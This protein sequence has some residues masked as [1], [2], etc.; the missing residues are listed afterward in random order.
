M[1]AGVFQY[2][3]HVLEHSLNPLGSLSI[4]GGFGLD[5]TER[6]YPTLWVI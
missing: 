4:P 6:S 1:L 5:R 2:G 3:G